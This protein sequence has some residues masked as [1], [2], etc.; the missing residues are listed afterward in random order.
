MLRANCIFMY[1]SK[2][3]RSYR[4]VDFISLFDAI[5]NTAW[6]FRDAVTD[7]DVAAHVL[8]EKFY[9]VFDQFASRR[10]Q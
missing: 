8:N 6:D 4:K 2:N 10:H 1:D 3:I 7:I 5:I 9:N